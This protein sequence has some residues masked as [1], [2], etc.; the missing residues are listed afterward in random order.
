[1]QTIIIVTVD[2]AQ[3]VLTVVLVLLIFILKENIGWTMVGLK[4][5]GH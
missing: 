2:I 3:V 1:M 4:L 5:G